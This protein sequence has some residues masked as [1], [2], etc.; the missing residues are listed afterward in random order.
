MSNESAIEE[1][2][3]QDFDDSVPK[4][5]SKSDSIK[6]ESGLKGRSSSSSVDAKKPKGLKGSGKFGA[7]QASGSRRKNVREESADS[8]VEDVIDEESDI[9]ED[10][11]EEETI[12]ELSG[13]V[14]SKKKASASL[15]EESIIKEEYSQDNFDVYDAS[16][17]LAAR[18]RVRF[19]IQ[20]GSS[21]A[22][23]PPKTAEEV[24]KQSDALA[25]LEDREMATLERKN[26]IG[27]LLNE[28]KEYEKAT[29]SSTIVERM[30]KV[31]VTSLA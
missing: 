9:A 11:I 31:V 23:P 21:R 19:G 20:T 7:S 25:L 16:Q 30:E 1:E 5:E 29:M 10:T 24:K 22:A 4:S 6:E 15:E 26:M 12:A 18:N 14:S 28:M 13:E 3:S 17:S 27:S 8:I 2:Y